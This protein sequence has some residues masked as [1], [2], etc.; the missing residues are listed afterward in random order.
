MLVILVRNQGKKRELTFF[1]SIREMSWMWYGY[2]TYYGV[3][4]I[5]KNCTKTVVV[6]VILWSETCL[7][8]KIVTLG[9]G[10]NAESASQWKQRRNACA[11]KWS[12]FSILECKV[13]LS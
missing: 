6:M 2:W 4:L 11:K 8:G 13:F 12:L 9:F 7:A 1:W 10:A 3:H 5:A